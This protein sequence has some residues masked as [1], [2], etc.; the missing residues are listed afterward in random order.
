[1]REIKIVDMTIRESEHH[2]GSDLSF[3]EKIEIA[4]L[5]ERLH[6]DVIE[7]GVVGNSMADTIA[8]R[9]IADTITASTVSCP[10]TLNKEN[11]D[12]TWAALAQAKF[13]RL[14]LLVPVST[15]QMEYVYQ[16]K[17]PAMLAKVE[18]L[19]AYCVSICP[20]IE[21]TAED[22]TRSETEFLYQVVAAAVKA[23]IKTVTLVDSAGQLLPE[24]VREFITDMHKNVPGLDKVALSVQVR[25]DLGLAT[26]NALTSVIS[27][28]SQIKAAISGVGAD[29]GNLALEEITHTLS[30]RTDALQISSRL[31]NVVLQQTCKQI[32]QL[33]G[34]TRGNSKAPFSARMPKDKSVNAENPITKLTPDSDI[35]AVSQAVAYLGYDLSNEDMERVYG[36]FA[37]LIAKKAVCERD[38]EAMI[39]ETVGQVQPTFVLNNYV[40]NSGNSITSTAVVS[41]MKNGEK[42]ETV[43][44]GDGPIDAAF[45]A[46]DHIHGRHVELEDF[47]I[48]A[49]TEG[50]EAMGDALVKIRYSGKL[51][52]GRGLSTDIIGASIQAYI[53]AINK[54]VC[55][56]ESV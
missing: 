52:S 51:Y 14:N 43:S 32:G 37:E 5:L 50:R 45:H 9:T 47:H 25:D 15:V 35:I 34:S 17:A 39:A 27:G 8:V 53:N 42:M 55:E 10:V 41:M 19:A 56:E 24:E 13:P 20:D 4:K 22:A 7:T 12:Q 11:I 6:V 23:G 54:M 21:F 31:N 16:L 40:I 44:T 33:I 2:R 48:E 30:S 49:V 38:L 28:C 3:K 46:I 1:M 18:E 36:Q 29:H 26:A